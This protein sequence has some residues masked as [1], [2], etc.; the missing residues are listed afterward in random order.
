MSLESGRVVDGSVEGGETIP[1]TAG[2]F[3]RSESRLISTVLRCSARVSI[4]CSSCVALRV[5]VI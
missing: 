2:V 4:E 3:G 5:I 1:L